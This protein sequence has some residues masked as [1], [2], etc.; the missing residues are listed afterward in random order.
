MGRSQAFMVWLIQCPHNRAQNFMFQSS[1]EDGAIRPAP[2]QS[3][4]TNAPCTQSNAE[5]SALRLVVVGASHMELPGEPRRHQA[6]CRRHD[7]LIGC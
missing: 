1:A 6:H 7:K 2:G 3:I 5:L 4:G